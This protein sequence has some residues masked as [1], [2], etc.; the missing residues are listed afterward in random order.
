MRLLL[1]VHFLHAEEDLALL[2]HPVEVDEL[3]RPGTKGVC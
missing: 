2:Q 3:F 1:Q